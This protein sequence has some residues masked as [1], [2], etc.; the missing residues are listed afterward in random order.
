MHFDD[1]TPLV[2]LD[3]TDDARWQRLLEAAQQPNPDDFQAI[4][5]PVSDPA[6]AGMSPHNAI[7]TF[8]DASPN[9]FIFADSATIADPEMAFLCVNRRMPE[10]SVRCIP[11]ELW[12]IENNVRLGNMGIEE[13]ANAA[14]NDGVF[15]GFL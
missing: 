10:E 5:Q 11:A 8:G 9:L 13:F 4:V 6:L 14:D 7:A 1:C 2:R 12:G 3:F 15:R